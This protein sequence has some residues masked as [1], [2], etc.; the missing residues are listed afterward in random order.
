MVTWQ[1]CKCVWLYYQLTRVLSLVSNMSKFVLKIIVAA[2]TVN[3][4]FGFTCFD[5]GCHLIKIIKMVLI[6]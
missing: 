6:G 1:G 4:V 5:H 3:T 2:T